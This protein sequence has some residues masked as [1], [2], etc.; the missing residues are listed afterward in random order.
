[1]K[2]RPNV[3]A[4]VT[5]PSPGAV[6]RRQVDVK[7]ETVILADIKRRLIALRDGDNEMFQSHDPANNRRVAIIYDL[8]AGST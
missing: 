4:V 7:L 2:M 6:V 8:G 1:M 5:P 3:L